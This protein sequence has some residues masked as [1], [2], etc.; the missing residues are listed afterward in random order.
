MSSCQSSLDAK[1]MKELLQALKEG[2]LQLAMGGQGNMP[3]PLPGMQPG[4]GQGKGGQKNRVGQGGGKGGS[5]AGSGATSQD[6]KLAPGKMTATKP[7]TQVKGQR[8]GASG[9]LKQDYKG[10][11]DGNYAA[12]T[13]LYQAYQ[14]GRRA[15]E[16]P[17]SRENIP[18]AYRKQVKEYFES[19]NPRK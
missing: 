12:S 13:P 14:S 19:I 4:Q 8:S 16:N 7:N 6:L 15:A 3:L 2:R 11:P 17:T 1:A 18:P 10:D 5:G 9:D